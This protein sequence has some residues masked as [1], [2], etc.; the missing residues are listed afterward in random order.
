MAIE[1]ELTSV[2]RS[3]LKNWSSEIDAGSLLPRRQ[4]EPHSHQRGSLVPSQPA[5]P[6]VELYS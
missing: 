6:D 4:Y 1:N 2:M 5:L 3:W